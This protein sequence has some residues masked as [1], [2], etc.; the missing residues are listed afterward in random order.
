MMRQP[1][2]FRTLPPQRANTRE[3]RGSALI[4]VLIASLLLC[5]GTVAMIRWTTI[6]LRTERDQN[7]RFEV[8]RN[9]AG[10][11]DTGVFVNR[12]G[13]AGES[14]ATQAVT[15]NT[16]IRIS[17]EDQS[18]GPAGSP[19]PGVYRSVTATW[20]GPHGTRQHLVIHT[21]WYPSRRLY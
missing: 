11:L 10:V 16:M 2:I 14:S 8:L 13:S 19:A 7:L 3:E 1:T 5:A 21:F 6:L 20:E 17:L 18:P 15:G 12:P 9:L 4:V